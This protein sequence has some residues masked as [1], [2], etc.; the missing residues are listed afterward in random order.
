MFLCM[1]IP[2][3]LIESSIGGHLDGLHFLAIV[4]TASVNI[5][6]Q[7]SVLACDIPMRGLS[8]SCVNYG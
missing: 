1:D 4:N 6:V 5:Y 2:C 3:L 8:G 7:V